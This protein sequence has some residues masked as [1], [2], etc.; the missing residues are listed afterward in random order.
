MYES[1]FVF[2]I[3][4]CKE[5]GSLRMGVA[6]EIGHVYPS[7]NVHAHRHAR[8]DSIYFS[9]SLDIQTNGPT[10]LIT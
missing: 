2:H 7:S 6:E 5:E 3:S 4:H 10:N 1:L 8:A 9:C